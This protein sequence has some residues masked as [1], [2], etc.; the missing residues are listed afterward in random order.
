MISNGLLRQMVDAMPTPVFVMDDSD[1]YVYVNR[2]FELLF[3]VRAEHVLGR[4]PAPVKGGSVNVLRPSVPSCPSALA[5]TT[6][7]TLPDGGRL[8]MG[9]LRTE[10]AADAAAT[11]LQRT[12]AELH[13]ARLELARVE[14]TDPVTHC[15]SPRAL[16]SHTEAVLAGERVGV[17]RM[18]LDDLDIVQQA[19]G[20]EIADRLLRSFS[21]IVRS[22]TRPGDL[23]ARVSDQEFTLVL[24]NADRTQ[25]ATV[26]RRVCSAMAETQQADGADG[27]NLS[28]S[29]G[30]AFSD[31]DDAQLS[32]IVDQAGAA[33]SQA[34]RNE[35]V[36]V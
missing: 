3:Q 24:R 6:V 8:V 14:E 7:F 19:C 30:A 23:F 31:D 29:V 9:V 28:V 15:L 25:T 27:V 5:E 18:R 36:M 1:R 20:D 10:R 22:V 4:R 33:L 32:S 12:R 11:E 26:A 17:V 2:A 13:A 35:A 16:R 34:A 21:E